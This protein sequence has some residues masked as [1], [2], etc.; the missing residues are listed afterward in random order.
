MYTREKM[1]FRSVKGKLAIILICLC[2]VPIIVMGIISDR[3]INTVLYKNLKTNSNQNV[4]QVQR[5]INTYF[6]GMESYLN[7][8]SQSPYVVNLDTNADYKSLMDNLMQSVRS[9]NKDIMNLYF[10]QENKAF[11]VCPAQNLPEGFDPTSRDWYKN[12]VKGKGKIIYTDP[13]KDAGSGKLV[14]SVSK[15]VER[16]NKVVGVVGMDI[17]I[18]ELSQKL[19][20]IKIGNA[21]YMCITDSKG[22]VIANPNKDVIGKSIENEMNIWNKINNNKSGFEE[23]KYKS[24]TKYATYSTSD[25][26]GWKL[27]GVLNEQ[28]LSKDTKVIKNSTYIMIFVIGI[29]ALGISIMLTNYLTRRLKNLRDQFSR[30]AN[31]D[32]SVSININSY[33]EIGELAKHFNIMMEHIKDLVKNIKTSSDTIIKGSQSINVMAEK[34]NSAV[35]EVSATLDQIAQGSTEQAQHISASSERVENLGNQ[36]DNIKKLTESMTQ[37]SNYSNQLG[38]EGLKAIQSL[39]EKT[40]M[41]NTSVVKVSK[42]ILDMNSVTSQIGGITDAIDSIAEQTNLLALNASI[43]SARAGEAGKGFA[44]VAEEIR[45]LSEESSESAKKIKSLIQGVKVKSESAVE[46]IKK[47]RDITEEQNKAVGET[48]RILGEIIESIKI[49]L[50]QINTVKEFTQN[51]DESKDELIAR[52]QNITAISEEASASTE[53]I[54]SASQEIAASMSEFTNTSAKLNDLSKELEKEMNKFKLN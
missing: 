15:S 42:A 33:D 10:A 9:G 17:N 1:Q 37:K 23:Y 34:N 25:I 20:S 4:E 5:D 3:Q 2:L 12:A 8:L 26:T 53:E 46:S 36:I 43:E 27:I 44:V 40:E 31:G 35:N 6:S 41:N 11:N 45:K 48:K 24:E 14:I 13:Y 21:G 54:S 16:D 29:I 52:M 28:E 7:M 22:I 51:T 32:L 38:K 47:A 49:I 19:S 50:N 18:A 30:A 39:T